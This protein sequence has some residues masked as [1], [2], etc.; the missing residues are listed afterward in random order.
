MR[1]H[2]DGHR[3][4]YQAVFLG[5]LI[6]LVFGLSLWAPFVYDDV[7]FI[8][9]DRS[10]T[11]PWLGFGHW[12]LS[13]LSAT[14]EY[15]PLVTLIHRLI[16]GMAAGRPFPYRLTSLLLHWGNAVLVLALYR[17]LL[18]E[19]KYYFW[20]A[21]L[22]T[23]Y[24]AHTETLVVSTFKKHLLVSFFG[25]ILIHFQE[26]RTLARPWRWG[27]CCLAMTLALLSK[28]SALILP[29]LCLLLSLGTCP[30]W[31]QRLKED[32]GLYAGLTIVCGLSS[33]S[34]S[35]PAQTNGAPGGGH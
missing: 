8:L 25:L 16:Y 28:E 35:C 23:L 17:R 29:P 30:Q 7:A 34:G 9:K 4:A 18:G 15:E 32:A 26:W 1:T 11:G 21:V 14:T 31:R 24:P 22:F 27:V 2:V 6:G 10:V 19:G 3:F 13:P 5:A 12:L 33:A 20:A